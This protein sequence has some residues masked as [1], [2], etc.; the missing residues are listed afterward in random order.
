MAKRKTPSRSQESDA[1]PASGSRTSA[2][3]SR[4]RSRQGPARTPAELRGATRAPRRR[5]PQDRG[6]DTRA[7]L[8]DAALDAFGEAGFEAAS[9]RRIANKARVN[10]AAITYHFGSKRALHVAVA[11]HIAERIAAGIGPALAVAGVQQSFDDPDAARRAIVGLLGVFIDVILG[12][13]EAARW[14]LFVVREQMRPTAAFD[15]LYQFIGG[16]SGTASRLV[17]A[18][19]GRPEDAETRL[20]FLSIIGQVLFFRVA[21]AV[22]FR[23]MEWT[24][25]GEAERA[26]IKRVVIG[27]VEDILIAERSR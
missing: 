20:R 23:R 19:L 25:I 6:A 11:R 8:I 13:A 3:R 1:P 10:L 22:V 24:A 15:V 18:A 2:A 4:A 16:A 21:Q 27:N 9:T 5:A 26:A 14:S 12:Q 7:R 17:A